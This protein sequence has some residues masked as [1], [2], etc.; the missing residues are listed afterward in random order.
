MDGHFNPKTLDEEEIDFMLEP[1]QAGFRRGGRKAADRTMP[2]G[3]ATKRDMETSLHEEN[4]RTIE[5]LMQALVA[6]RV[7]N[8]KG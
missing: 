4:L 7:R 5:E 1:I 2:P 8:R 6:E 3:I